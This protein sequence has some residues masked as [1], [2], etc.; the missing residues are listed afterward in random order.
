MC[1]SRNLK[2]STYPVI[3]K[4]H[5]PCASCT[6]PQWIVKLRLKTDPWVRLEHQV[7]TPNF[8][9][10]I[11]KPDTVLETQTWFIQ[12]PGCV[13]RVQKRRWMIYFRILSSTRETRYAACPTSSCCALT[14][15]LSIIGMNLSGCQYLNCFLYS[16][17]SMQILKNNATRSSVMSCLLGKWW[18][19]G[20]GICRKWRRNGTFR[21]A[22][23]R[24]S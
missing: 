19:T 7:V 12:G 5:S 10:R 16:P 23:N 4:V 9:S 2:I 6:I 20:Q 14:T 13:T 21:K 17:S 3:K 22:A 15:C 11:F 8:L 18:N 1:S 24:L